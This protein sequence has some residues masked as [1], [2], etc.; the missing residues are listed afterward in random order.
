[1]TAPSRLPKLLRSRTS[2][3]V[4][5]V[6]ARYASPVSDLGTQCPASDFGHTS[7]LRLPMVGSIRC[8]KAGCRIHARGPMPETA[9]GNPRSEGC[10]ARKRALRESGLGPRNAVSRLRLRAL[11]RLPTSDGRIDRIDPMS[12]GRMSDPCRRSDAG[13]RVRKSE[14]GAGYYNCAVTAMRSRDET[15]TPPGASTVTAKSEALPTASRARMGTST[16]PVPAGMSKTPP[17]TG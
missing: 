4:R 8:P 13:N 9:F 15:T 6:S 5:H 2:A 3:T 10:A 11:I 14:V 1:M 12:E 17:S 16:S 7:G